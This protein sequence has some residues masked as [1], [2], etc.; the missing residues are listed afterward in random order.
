MKAAV[1]RATVYFDPKIHKAL[2]IKAAATERSLS[3][4]VN[5]AVRVALTEDAE[6]LEAF[7]R[8]ANEPNLLFEEVLQDL[9]NR[10]QI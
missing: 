4:I 7:D 3:E 1:K 9:K 6:D 2:R 5:E 8:R 10:G